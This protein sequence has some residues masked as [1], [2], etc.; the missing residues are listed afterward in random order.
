M[1][2]SFKTTAKR[3]LEAMLVLA[4]VMLIFLGILYT[5]NTVFPTGLTLRNLVRPGG[6]GSSYYDDHLAS[7]ELRLNTGTG[8]F[9]LGDK[10]ATTAVLTRNYN[11]VRTKRHNQ[12]TW[13][14]ATTG[15][16]FQSR[17][18]IQTF[19]NSSATVLFKKGNYLELDENSLIV[20]R[21]MEKDIFTRE[22]RMT[23]VLMNGQ[24]SGQIAKVGQENFNL[25]VVAPGVVAR[26]PSRDNR[27]KPASF[28][29][30][31][32]PDETSTLTVNE[33]TVD[34]TVDGRTVEIQTD[35]VV[36]IQPGKALA[37]LRPPPGPPVLASPSD[38]KSYLFRDIPPEVSFDWSRSTKAQEYHYVLAMD[39]SFKEI[40]H[41]ERVSDNSFFHGNLDQG[42]YFWRVSAVNSDGEGEFS[43][44]RR[45][46]LIQDLELPTLM[47][48]YPEAGEEGDRF[49]LSGRTDPDARIFVGGIPVKVD[50]NGEFAHDLFLS[51]G[52]N[53]IVVEAV[54]KVGN[55]NYFSKTINVEF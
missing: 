5:L 42:T 9:G 31:V 4:L 13:H 30:T 21:N 44:A 43:Q 32:G 52:Y 22:N 54:D 48:D 51:R 35:Q 8:D 24:V 38:G 20:L 33:G 10:A 26:A 17:D 2:L 41:E 1:K 3:A 40:V 23:V 15:M 18:G 46:E 29:M 14:D 16:T 55:V 53:V 45:I 36:R 25:E 19:R 27:D 37:Y 34:I 49:E 11:Q 47:V 39:R 28:K 7:R 50:E 12:V 6:E